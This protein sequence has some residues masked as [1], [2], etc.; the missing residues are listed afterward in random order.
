VSG[1]YFKISKNSQRLSAQKIKCAKMAKID[2]FG[3][4]KIHK[5]RFDP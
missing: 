3:P 2:E 1:N 4:S 5:N